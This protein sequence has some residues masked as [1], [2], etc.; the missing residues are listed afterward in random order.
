[1]DTLC[2]L[3]ANISE[4]RAEQL[5]HALSD[6]ERFPDSDSLN[7]LRQ[8]LGAAI[9]HGL[10]DLWRALEEQG[11]FQISSHQQW[12]IIGPLLETQEFQQLI[13]GAILESITGSF[14]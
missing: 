7:A 11:L 14:P 13:R 3:H 12:A 5:A 4:D 9:V 1:M 6:L 10:N 8:V 2:T